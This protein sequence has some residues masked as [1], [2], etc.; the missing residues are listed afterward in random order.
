MSTKWIIV[1]PGEDAASSQEYGPY[2]SERAAR[3]VVEAW[4]ST[5]DPDDRAEV[6]RLLPPVNATGLKAHAGPALPA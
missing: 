3:E 6:K 1:L 2:P 4:N 5:A